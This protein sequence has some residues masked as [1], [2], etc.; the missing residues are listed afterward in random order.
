[1]TRALSKLL[2]LEES[3]AAALQKTGYF[4]P[5][6]IFLQMEEK[7]TPKWS[8]HFNKLMNT[9]RPQETVDFGA[10]DN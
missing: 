10:D 6:D 1:M 5:H 8:I 9:Q 7:L 4:L 3:R 2:P